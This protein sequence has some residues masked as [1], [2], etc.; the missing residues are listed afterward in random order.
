MEFEKLIMI[1]YFILLTIFMLTGIRFIN[2]IESKKVSTNLTIKQN[3]Y[4]GMK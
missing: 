2:T 4:E 1:L 3:I